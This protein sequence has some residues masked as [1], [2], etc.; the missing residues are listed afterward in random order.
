MNLPVILTN[1]T[2]HPSIPPSDVY[3]FG[4]TLFEL[5]TRREPYEGEEAL[6]VLEQVADDT[7]DPPKRPEVPAGVAVP[8]ILRDLMAECYH[9]N[10]MRRPTMQEVSR[11]GDRAQDLLPNLRI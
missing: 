8:P 6:L 7:L 4:I 2:C 9:K 10:P 3:S 1:T 11:W 5:L